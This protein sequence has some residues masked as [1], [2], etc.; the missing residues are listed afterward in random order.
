MSK[1]I[2]YLAKDSIYPACGRGG[3]FPLT[4]TKIEETTCGA[5]QNTA[6]GKKGAGGRRRNQNGRNKISCVVSDLAWENWNR[7]EKGLR[8]QTVSDL[9]EGL[10]RLSA[11][12]K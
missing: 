5:C 4:T 7:I 1:K 12:S 3:N 10:S 6:T 9:L 2:H 11:G 8:S